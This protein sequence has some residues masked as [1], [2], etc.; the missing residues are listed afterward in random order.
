M[1]V[2]IGLALLLVA[3]AVVLI[4]Y[5]VLGA[6]TPE[7]MAENYLEAVLSSDAKTV[8]A[9]LPDGVSEDVLEAAGYEDREAFCTRKSEDMKEML[10]LFNPIWGPG[11]TYEIKSSERWCSCGICLR[12]PF[13][14]PAAVIR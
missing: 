10:S 5:L 14:R 1:F 13:C 4:L 3:A 6:Q 8:V 11:W 9:M 12:T 7:S 2:L